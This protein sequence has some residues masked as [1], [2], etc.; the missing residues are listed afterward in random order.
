LTFE[1]SCSRSQLAGRRTL[2]RALPQ[3]SPGCG[4][5]Q[6]PLDCGWI[7]AHIQFI[8]GSNSQGAFRQGRSLPR[9]AIWCFRR[10]G[11]AFLPTCWRSWS[12]MLA[13]GVTQRGSGSRTYWDNTPRQIPSAAP[14]GARAADICACTAAY[15]TRWQEAPPSPSRKRFILG[16]PGLALP[17]THQGLGTCSTLSPPP[18]S[19]GMRPSPEERGAWAIRAAGDISR[20]SEN[21]WP[22]LLDR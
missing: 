5:A 17:Q 13:Q 16:G 19:G 10:R 1:C 3:K 18:R 9:W 8:T 4:I 14:A 6:P 2:S 11:P 7:H 15:R 12:T 22:R 20:R 21:G